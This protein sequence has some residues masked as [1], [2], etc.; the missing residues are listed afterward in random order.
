MPIGRT[1]TAEE[2]ARYLGGI[3]AEAVKIAA[4]AGR[5]KGYRDTLFPGGPWRF[6]KDD[7][8]AY[9]ESKRKRV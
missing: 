2:A 4:R 9:A 3:G 7:L 8:D 5:L 1:F 6:A